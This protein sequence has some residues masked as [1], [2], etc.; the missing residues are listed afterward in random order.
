MIDNKTASEEAVKFLGSFTTVRHG[1][2]RTELVLVKKWVGRRL[3]YERDFGVGPESEQREWFLGLL[4]IARDKEL[5]GTQSLGKYLLTDWASRSQNIYAMPYHEGHTDGNINGSFFATKRYKLGLE[6]AKI[7]KVA[8]AAN[9]RRLIG[10]TTR[11]K[12]A[13][14][15]EKIRLKMTKGDAAYAIAEIVK[16]DSGTIRRYLTELFPGDKWKTT[17]H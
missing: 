15:A 3:D 2:S 12:V 10:A 16:K 11:A 1:H 4:Q 7:S 6:K 13:K 17:N 5:G 14:E 8:R 9:G